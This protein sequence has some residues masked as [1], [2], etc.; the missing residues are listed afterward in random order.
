MECLLASCPL[1]T[2]AQTNDVNFNFRQF[3]RKLFHVSL[4][5]ILKSLRPGEVTPEA[6]HAWL[7]PQLYA[8]NIGPTLLI[9]KHRFLSN[10]TTQ[11]DW[12]SESW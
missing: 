4:S 12:L 2:K 10:A 7:Q 9:S 8:A 5:Y 3:R 6:S 11:Y 1:S